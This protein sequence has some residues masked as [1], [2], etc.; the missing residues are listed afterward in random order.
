[1]LIFCAYPVL[2][3]ADCKVDVTYHLKTGAK[4]QKTFSVPAENKAACD[5]QKQ[6]FGSNTSPNK[7]VKKVVRVTWVK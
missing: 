4:N 3:A 2:A 1:M 6:I 7:V 5:R